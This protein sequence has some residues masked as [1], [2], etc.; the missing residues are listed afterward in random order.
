[1]L[2]EGLREIEAEVRVLRTIYD[3]HA[4]V[5]DRFTGAGI[6]TPELAT[7][8]GLTGLAGRASAQA[9]D[10]RVDLPYTPYQHCAVTKM[11]RS[12]GDVAARVAIRFDEIHESCRIIQHILATM[13]SGG[14]RA[15]VR[16]PADGSVGVGLIEGWRGPVSVAL[17]AGPAGTIRR[18]H[19]HDP[20]WQNWPVI[21]HAIIGNIVPDFPLIN[22]SFNLSYSGHD[23]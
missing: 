16:M 11:V 3:E 2:N 12:E 23:L 20:S 13:P 5:R 1:L 18:C 9:F 4:G 17:E 19:P 6:V 8:L 10:L 15:P 21:E 22:K 7:R 14:H